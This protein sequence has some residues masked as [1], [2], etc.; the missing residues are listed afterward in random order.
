MELEIQRPVLNYEG[1]FLIWDHP[2]GLLETGEAVY[3]FVQE[4]DQFRVRTQRVVCGVSEI[5]FSNTSQYKFKV[6]R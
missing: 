5:I 3:C 1:C 6:V 4:A 2:E